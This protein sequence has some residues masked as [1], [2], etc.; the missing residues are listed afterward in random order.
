MYTL[1]YI[2]YILFTVMYGQSDEYLDSPL[3]HQD[4]QLIDERNI[5]AHDKHYLRLLAH[6]LFTLKAIANSLE[7]IDS[8]ALPHQENCLQW[9]IKKKGFKKEE[10]FVAVFLEQLDIASKQLDVL[11]KHYS[12]SPL[13]LSLSQLI[14]FVEKEGSEQKS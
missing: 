1:G 8:K 6:C 3:S 9:L 4:I 11:G 2:L 7:C 5:A 14:D 13:E 12:V 10:Y